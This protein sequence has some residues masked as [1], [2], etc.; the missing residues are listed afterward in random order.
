MEDAAKDSDIAR[1]CHWCR[2][3]NHTDAECWSTRTRNFRPDGQRTHFSL[4]MILPGW[5]MPKPMSLEDL[6]I[7]FGGK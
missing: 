2:K 1:W 6:L 5:T 7:R 3:D 4:G